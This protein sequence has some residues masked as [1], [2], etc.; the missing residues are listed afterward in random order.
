MEGTM[1]YILLAGLLVG[2]VLVIVA[3]TIL[4]FYVWWNPLIWILVGVGFYQWNRG[5]GFLY[6]KKESIRKF[7]KRA[8]ES[9]L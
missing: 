3:A 8:R 6:W 9:D 7:M 1:R 4:I 5:G 2:D